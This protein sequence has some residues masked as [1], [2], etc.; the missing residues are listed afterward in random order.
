[1]DTSVTSTPIAVTPEPRVPDDASA[2]GIHTTVTRRTLLKLGAAA[3][4]GIAAAQLLDTWAPVTAALG[5]ESASSAAGTDPGAIAGS[6]AHEWAFGCDATKCI[7]CGR[8]VEACKLE[9]DI[10]LEPEF[11]RTWV[12]RHVVGTDGTVHVDSPDG[13]IHGFR[14]A[15]TAPGSPTGDAVAAAYFVPRLCM[16]C[17]DP[18]CVAV[19]P[20]SATFKTDGGVVLV[21]Q[22]RCIGCGYCVV[23]CPYGARYL[24]PSGERTPTG[25]AGVADKCTWCYHRIENG[26]LPACVEICPA[27]AR[28]FGDLLDDESP[29][30]AFLRETEHVVLKPEMATKPRVF[31]AGLEAEVTA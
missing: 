25:N 13:G 7:G 21:D 16:Q 9:N 27:G 20:V 28:V 23:A 18:P 24:V 15:S 4:S 17:D 3:V 29:I 10:P 19:C 12:E 6:T 31:Y 5:A 26:R 8:C 30:S 1:M 2:T 11:N 22:E 14:G